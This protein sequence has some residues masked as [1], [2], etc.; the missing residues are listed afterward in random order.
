MTDANETDSIAGQMHALKTGQQPK[1]KPV[2]HADDSSED[3]S[4]TEGD[5]GD[6]SDTNTET[7]EE[8]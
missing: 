1:K 8:D 6:T 4:D 7:D 2:Q 5:A 3:D